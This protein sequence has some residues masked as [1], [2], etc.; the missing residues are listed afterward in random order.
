MTS[1]WLVVVLTTLI[2]WTS[3]VEAWYRPDPNTVGYAEDRWRFYHFHF[4]LQEISPHFYFQVFV[5]RRMTWAG[6]HHMAG[7][8]QWVTAWAFVALF[9]A[10]VSVF[11]KCGKE[12]FN[13]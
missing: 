10:I 6:W 3:L 4:L 1:P 5:S 7:V 8:P 2:Q 12:D 9:V 11:I 13:L